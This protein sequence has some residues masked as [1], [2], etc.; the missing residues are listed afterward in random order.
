M[1]KRCFRF[2]VRS[3]RILGGGSDTSIITLSKLF[4]ELD[5]IRFIEKEFLKSNIIGRIAV[6]MMETITLFTDALK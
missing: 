5:V 6:L 1:L 2:S 4:D 3:Q